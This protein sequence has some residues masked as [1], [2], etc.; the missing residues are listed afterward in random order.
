MFDLRGRSL[1]ALGQWDAFLSC[2]VCEAHNRGLVH[3]D[4]S[5]PPHAGSWRYRHASIT[6][7]NKT[8][9]VLVYRLALSPIWSG[10]TSAASLAH[11][12]PN[13]STIH[14]SI[15]GC[16]IFYF[17]PMKNL[18]LKIYFV[19]SISRQPVTREAQAS[20]CEAPVS[21]DLAGDSLFSF[22]HFI[23]KISLK[24]GLSTAKLYPTC[25]IGPSQVS[26]E[27]LLRIPR[28]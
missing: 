24:H 15:K 18:H 6:A 25:A 9:R 4:S 5:I 28:E 12:P 8:E 19:P 27:A 21:T 1:P 22:I 13:K 2:V 3:I 23:E 11:S 17:C 7:K 10:A 14:S 26:P 16:I 20:S